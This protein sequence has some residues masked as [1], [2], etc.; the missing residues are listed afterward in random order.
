MSYKI[1]ALLKN[2]YRFIAFFSP[3][4]QRNIVVFYILA[5][6]NYLLF[7]LLLFLLKKAVHIQYY[8]IQLA[9]IERILINGTHT[10]V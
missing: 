9:C 10:L 2:N 5:D 8:L 6:S 1:D 7:L 3:T 4:T